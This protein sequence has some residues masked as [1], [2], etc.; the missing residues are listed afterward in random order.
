MQRA[1][2]RVQAGRVGLSPPEVATATTMEA[3]GGQLQTTDC[4]RHRV[5]SV[6]DETASAAAQMWA[7]GNNGTNKQSKSRQNMAGVDAGGCRLCRVAK[8]RRTSDLLALGEAK[9]GSS[10]GESSAGA[11]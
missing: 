3:D 5:S 7:A 6:E 4:C 1:A 11:G 9:S 2:D 8:G 10:D